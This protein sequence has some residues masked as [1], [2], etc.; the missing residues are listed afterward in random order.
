MQCAFGSISSARV[1]VVRLLVAAVPRVLVAGEL[2][3]L[4]GGVLR[5]ARSVP[6]SA[7]LRSRTLLLLLLLLML[8]CCCCYCYQHHLINPELCPV[9]RS[10]FIRPFKSRSHDV[11]TGALVAR[12]QNCL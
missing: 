2:Q 5:H 11:W 9:P 8:L 4:R 6:F 1:R 12:S 3:L 10:G 7:L